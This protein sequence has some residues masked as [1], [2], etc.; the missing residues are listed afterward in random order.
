MAR[1]QDRYAHLLLS[2]DLEALPLR[3]NGIPL[4]AGQRLKVWLN[5]RAA[6]TITYRRGQIAR[7]RPAPL[8]QNA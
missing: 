5:C 6:A 4:S 8:L 3:Q 7:R 1:R 2:S